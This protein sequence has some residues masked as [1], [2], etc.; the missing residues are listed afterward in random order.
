MDRGSGPVRD[1][2]GLPESWEPFARDILNWLM[3]ECSRNAV[4]ASFYALRRTR[5]EKIDQ[6][7]AVTI[8]DVAK[9]AGLAVGTVSKYLNGR[10]LR[11]E[12]R[13]KIERAIQELGFK[14]N[15][16]ARGLKGNRTMTIAVAIPTYMAIFFMAA[17]TILEEILEQ[18]NYR[19]LIFG[20]NRNPQKLQ[21]KLK[22]AKERL[23]DGLILFASYV[24]EKDLPILQEYLNEHIP[25]VLVEQGVPR[26][27]TD[28]VMVD[29]AHASFRAVERLILDNHTRIALV[30][31]PDEVYVFQERR[32]GYY[33]AMRTYNLPVDEHW[34]ISGTF[35]KAGEYTAIR[36]I[37][38]SAHPPTAVYTTNYHATIGAVFTLHERHLRIP[39]DISLV[40]FDHFDPMDAIDPPLTLVEQPIE[41]IAQ[42]AADLVLKRIKGD[43]ADF[44][45][46]ITLNTRMLMRDSVRKIY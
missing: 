38:A 28:T 22:L 5:P 36:K 30:N 10:R 3:V 41:E 26:I 32:R 31:G 33:D 27:A 21:E 43:Y 13:L 20:F 40:G 12:N 24:G 11:E 44:P 46:T 9:R 8:H 39:E 19:I 35:I 45:Q 6:N 23:V 34:V 14:A 16:L 29:N 17:A 7:M 1:D 37:F 42:T 2:S 15:I 18:A 25:V 4:L